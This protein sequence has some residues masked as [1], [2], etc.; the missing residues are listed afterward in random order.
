MADS[1][2]YGAKTNKADS[3]PAG[4]WTKVLAGQEADAVD[5]PTTILRDSV[6]VAGVERF[7]PPEKH[8]APSPVEGAL[9]PKIKR[10][11][12]AGENAKEKSG[13]RDM[14]PASFGSLFDLAWIS[15]H[16]IAEI[17]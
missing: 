10:A 7:T 3:T 11:E 9:M 15:L 13:L 12:T 8:G 6:V 16:V 5:D 4:V 1:S 17:S 14:I 2:R